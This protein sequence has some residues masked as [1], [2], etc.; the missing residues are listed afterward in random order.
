[1]EK[2]G[3]VEP[4]WKGKREFSDLKSELDLPVKEVVVAR[5]LRLYPTGK[6]K[7]YFARCFG[8]HRFFYNRAVD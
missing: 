5:K 4:F 1:M 3:K 7:S 6:Q 8:A 2:D